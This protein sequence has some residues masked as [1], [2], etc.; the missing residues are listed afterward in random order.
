MRAAIKKRLGQALMETAQ[1]VGAYL[2][3][4]PQ[5]G[6]CAQASRMIELWSHGLRMI[7]PATS[8][9]LMETVAQI[10]GMDCEPVSRPTRPAG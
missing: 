7:D 9:V 10:E 4:K 8:E 2:R 5:Q 6:L 1:E 3:E